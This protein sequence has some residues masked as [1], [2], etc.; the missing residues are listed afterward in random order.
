MPWLSVDWPELREQLEIIMFTSLFGSI[1]LKDL[2]CSP[3][4][5]VPLVE[6]RELA[7][8]KLIA[9]RLAPE[10]RLF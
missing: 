9:C 10:R 1:Q 4:T 8:E 5:V 2:G 7:R 3:F 6:L